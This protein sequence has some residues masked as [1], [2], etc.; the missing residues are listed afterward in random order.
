MRK[1]Q[2]IPLYDIK[3]RGGEHIIQWRYGAHPTI[4][5]F[6]SFREHKSNPNDVTSSNFPINQNGRIG[7]AKGAL[8]ADSNTAAVSRHPNRKT[9]KISSSSKN[10]NKKEKDEFKLTETEEIGLR[11]ELRR[12]LQEVTRRNMKS[13]L[14]NIRVQDDEGKGTLRYEKV[15]EILQKNQISLSELS[16]R[17]LGRKFGEKEKEYHVVRYDSLMSYVTKL[18]SEASVLPKKKPSTPP[19]A[20]FSNFEDRI[21]GTKRGSFAGP[22]ERIIKLRNRVMFR[23]SDEA[24]LLFDLQNELSTN[25]SANLSDLRRVM[26]NFDR[27]RNNFLNEGQVYASF[28]KCGIY[29][30]PEVFQQLLLATDR[31][32][33]GA[34]D[35]E[36]LLNYLVRVRP[37]LE[38]YLLL[39]ENHNPRMPTVPVHPNLYGQPVFATPGYDAY[40]STDYQ[41]EDEILEEYDSTVEE[42]IEPFDP[43]QWSKDFRNITEALDQVDV[44]RTG[45]LPENEVRHVASNYILVY[46]LGISKA[47][48]STALKRS[49]DKGFNE[50]NLSQFV[51]YLKDLHI[52]SL[53][54]I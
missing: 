4:H 35:I 21:S 8:W 52:K 18:W 54:E 3:I 40:P 31:T 44:D 34:Y 42:D 1:R 49:T 19:A 17:N 48:L 32:G 22:E 13:I 15:K 39:G 30:S 5:A 37:D 38:Y 53:E 6:N 10:S 43:V 50:I 9:K 14:P 27:D 46:N 12:A 36:T 20:G 16:F 23:D 41:E 45:F 26:Y 51:K 24:Q 28:Q 33:A 2:F 29:L 7:R 11:N 25:E 47:T